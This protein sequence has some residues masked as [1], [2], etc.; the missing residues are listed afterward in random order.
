MLQD[1]KFALRQLRKTPGFTLI[2]VVTL[3]LGIGANTAIF[4][5][6]NAVLLKPLPFPDS[7]QL[8]AIGASD[9]RQSSDPGALGTV[10]YPDFEDYRT[11]NTTFAA[12]AA[13]RSRDFAV[14]GEGEAQ[15]V[16]GLRVSA[17]LFEVLGVQP[18][19]GR[20][21]RAEEEAAGGGPEGLTTILSYALWQRQFAG[22]RNVLGRAINLD[23]R[24]HTVVGVMP[25]GFEFPIDAETYEI[26]VTVAPEATKLSEKH[27][28][29][30]QNRGNHSYQSV[31]RLK[32]GVTIDEARAELRTIAAA[33]EQQHPNTNT[34]VGAALYALR[35]EMVGDVSG[36]LYVLFGAVSCVLLIASA[37]VANLLLAR[38]TVRA[39]EI[40]VR[41]ALGARRGR[42]IRQ[43]ITESV[44]LAAMGGALGLMIA[45]WG[46]DLL[47]SL[48]PDDIPRV[49]SVK[50]DP[51]VLG[52][53]FI[54]ALGT[55]VLFGLAPAVQASKLDLREA[56]N[57]GGRG[58]GGGG[59]QWM[60]SGLVIAEVAVALVLL[61][62]A[63]LLLQT[64]DR[65]SRVSPGLQTSG[66]FTATLTA[67]YVTYPKPENVAQ[68]YDQLLTRVKTLPGVVSA[69]TIQPLPLS[70]DSMGVSFDVEERPLPQ[71]QQPNAAV[72]VAGIDFFQ[73]AGIPL[74]RGRLFNADD[75]RDGNYVMIVNA[76]FAEKHFPGEDVVGKRIQPGLSSDPGPLPMR[77]IVGVVGNIKSKSMSADVEPEMYLPATQTPMANTALVIRTATS[78]PLTITGAVRAELAQLNANIP[79]ASVRTFDSYVGSSLARARFNAT[80]LSIFAGVALLLTAIGIYGV[81]A[82]SVAQRRQEIG[83]RMALGA[84]RGDV[85]KMVLGSGMKLAALGVLIGVSAALAF[86]RILETLL[87]GVKAFDLVTFGAVSVLLGSIALLACWL[88][89]RRAA[90]VNPL[91]ALRA[92]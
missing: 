85:L 20:T 42:I 43:L 26:Y 18:A 35:D 47:V 68:F 57:E 32:P 46:T 12:M 27:V 37:N 39:K 16:Q 51:A 78:D 13:Y 76:R 1:I 36:A 24:P 73:T 28:P 6:V 75:R 8:V 61:T 77:E 22:D 55:G 59:R 4:S 15:N 89:A 72:R 19:L 14:G 80:L 62:G 90:G 70:G 83:I 65:L 82:Y 7:E 81:M 23:G 49:S 53:T 71:G 58:A 33:L 67:P 25:R 40:A 10:S 87:Y 92:D 84:Q 69:S 17:G 38:A 34:N 60:R 41:S 5:V 29:M 11:Q 45:A 56:L 66:L 88:P 31:G 91:V 21:F 54:V 2:A 63:G 64:F 30:T 9:P 86:T 3:A 44:L 48:V 52:F 79:L 74:V 50:V